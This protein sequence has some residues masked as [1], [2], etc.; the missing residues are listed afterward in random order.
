MTIIAGDFNAMAMTGTYH[1]NL[2]FNRNSSFFKDFILENEFISVNS[3]F[4][5][6]KRYTFYGMNN[7]KVIL[8]YILVRKK[9]CRSM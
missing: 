3:M 2:K 9:W 1:E 6:R 4:R 8:D 7:R 5:K